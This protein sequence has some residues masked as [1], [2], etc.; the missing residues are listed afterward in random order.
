MNAPTLLAPPIIDATRREFLAILAAAGL[1]PVC[2][3]DAAPP[4]A[5][6]EGI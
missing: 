1:L 6:N 2:A 5:H 3:S 4:S